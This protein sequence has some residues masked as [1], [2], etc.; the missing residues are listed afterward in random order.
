M[1]A[2]IETEAFCATFFFAGT[3]AEDDGR[4]LDFTLSVT[5]NEAGDTTSTDITY[6]GEDPSNPELAEKLI[7]EQYN[8]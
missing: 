5:T 3:L 4:E 8:K 6:I 1:K 7:L 2:F